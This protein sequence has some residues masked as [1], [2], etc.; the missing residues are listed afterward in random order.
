MQLD[1][2]P[3]AE[4]VV[5]VANYIRQQ[6]DPACVH[7]GHMIV[8]DRLNP[9]DRVFHCEGGPWPSD[10]CEFT[11]PDV[12]IV[13]RGAPSPSSWLAVE[14]DGS[15]HDTPAGRKHD[16]RRRARYDRAGVRFISIDYESDTWM[17]EL[18]GILLSYG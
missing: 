3:D 7:T 5:I 11:A 13:P 18:D 15:V 9:G 12:L 16:D 8:R 4:R 2:S 10:R 6:I 17:S 14:I 1:G